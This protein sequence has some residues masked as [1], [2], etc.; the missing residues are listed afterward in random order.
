MDNDLDLSIIPINQWPRE[1]Q[2][3]ARK[4]VWP[5]QKQF[6]EKYPAITRRLVTN[7]Y[8]KGGRIPK[9]NRLEEIHE[10]MRVQRRLRKLHRKMANEA[11]E[12]KQHK[13][14]ERQWQ[15]YLQAHGET[16]RLERIYFTMRE[17]PPLV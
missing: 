4:D 12:N 2:I 17:F 9:S 8:S 14:A 5:W 3:Y 11:E 10:K 1:A 7:R 16:I 15:Y 13:E 6:W